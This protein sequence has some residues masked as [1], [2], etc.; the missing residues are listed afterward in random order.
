MYYTLLF[1]FVSVC[2]L[3]INLLDF[4]H[5]DLELN[6]SCDEYFSLHKSVNHLRLYQEFDKIQLWII[7]SE[8]SETYV[9]PWTNQLIFSWPEIMINHE[10]ME[11]I[12]SIGN[13]SK[14][15]MFDESQIECEV[16]GISA[17]TLLVSEPEYSTYSCPEGENKSFGV[18]LI[19][20]AVGVALVLLLLLTNRSPESPLRKLAINCLQELTYIMRRRDQPPSYEDAQQNL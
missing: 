1:L 11:K 9:I 15:P 13:V 20:F 2:P 14:L 4:K 17:G 6:S 18:A 3:D 10:P 8:F 5:F 12:T 7:T 19:I 16:L